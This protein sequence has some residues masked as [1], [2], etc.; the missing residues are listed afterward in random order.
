[1]NGKPEVRKVRCRTGGGLHNWEYE[2]R[3]APFSHTAY[4]WRILNLKIL[5]LDAFKFSLPGG[6]DE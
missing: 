1:M 2:N 6:V 5:L 3:L 4:R